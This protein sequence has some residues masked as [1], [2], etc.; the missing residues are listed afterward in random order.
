M[1]EQAHTPGWSLPYDIPVSDDPKTARRQKLLRVAAYVVLVAAL[2][3]PVIQIQATTLKNLR[4]AREYDRAKEAGTLTEKQLRKGRPK[5]HKGAIARWAVAARAMWRGQNIYTMPPKPGEKRDVKPADETD[6]DDEEYAR[7]IH[8]HPNMPFVVMLIT[9]FAYLPITANALVFSIFKV[10]V[11]VCAILMAASAG[12]HRNL[13]MADWVMGLALGWSILLVIGD[14]QHGNTN[15]FVLGLLVLHVWLYRRG[16]DWWAGGALAVAVCIKMTPALFVL[17]WLYQRNWKL[18]GGTVLGGLILAVG[19]PAVVL[20]PERYIELT[21]TWLENLIIP[22]LIEG[23]WY[24]IHINQSIPGV[25]SRYFLDGQ[26][27]DIFWNADD[28]PYYRHGSPAWITFVDLGE[29]T[30]KMLIKVLQFIWVAVAAWA[31]G[32]R[33]LPRDDGRRML[34]WG[35]ITLGMMLLN[36]RTWDHH[37]GVL[38]L[39]ATGIWYALA[40]GRMEARTRQIALAIML[41]AGPLLWLGGTSTFDLA[42]MIAGRSDEVGEAWADYAKAYGPTFWYFVLLTAVSVILLRALKGKDEPYAD[43]RQPVFPNRATKQARR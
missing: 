20:G 33:K 21:G 18:L 23:A 38:L 43:H 1:I 42:A 19:L 22:G 37:A 4:K 14:I 10:G 24:P 29:Q 16:Q 40:Y 25:M 34:H 28:D 11:I 36:Q 41:L 5:G 32:W 12:K 17:Y 31:I 26:A 30:V 3:V 27:G 15:G 2:I 39:A 6:V 13:R 8:L 35:L 7:Q 9:P